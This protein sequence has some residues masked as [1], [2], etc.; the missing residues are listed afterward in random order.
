[1]ISFSRKL[2]CWTSEVEHSD[3]ECFP[4]LTEFLQESKTEL[5]AEAISDD[6]DHR[7]GLSGYLTMYFSNLE[8]MEHCWVE[9]NRKSTGISISGL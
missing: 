4:I 5:S 3:L 8:Y 9:S 2:Q 7:A 1:M 6:K